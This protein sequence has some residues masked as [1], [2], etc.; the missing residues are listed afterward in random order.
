MIENNSK[1]LSLM[2][3]DARKAGDLY[4]P[5]DYWKKKT[6]AAIRDIEKYGLEN[7]RD[8]SNIVGASFTDTALIDT[9]NFSS[10]GAR[11]LIRKLYKYVPPFKSLFDSQVAYTNNFFSKLNSEINEKITNTFYYQDILA[12]YNLPKNNTR[13]GCKT[14]CKLGETQISHHYMQMLMDLDYI[15]QK[16]PINESRTYF[17]IGGGYGAFA[18]C[19]LENYKN[20][21]KIVYLDIP[22]NLYVGT[23][24][25]K[26]F[27]GNSVIDY[28]E[29]R[30]QNVISFKDNDDLEIYCIAPWQI[31]DLACSIDFFHNAHSFVEMPKRVVINYAQ[32]IKKLLSNTGLISLITYSVSPNNSFTPEELPDAIGIQSGNFTL[33]S[34]KTLYSDRTYIHITS[35]IKL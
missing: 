13:G 4:S 22:P 14:F 10:T 27:F 8:G 29:S 23:Q 5:G 9:R 11:E 6:F 25:L 20:I 15:S 31:E 18:H 26:S 35:Q 3:S 33:S 24:Y 21:K 34:Q 1:L 32:Y 7:F 30:S 16:L 28:Q 17:E 12:R 19:L 2:L